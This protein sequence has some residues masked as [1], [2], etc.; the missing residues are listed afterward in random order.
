[1][2]LS[3]DKSYILSETKIKNVFHEIDD[4]NPELV[5]IDSIQ[6][7]QTQ[8]I[9]SS[10]GSVSQIKECTSELIGLQKKPMFLFF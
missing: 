1:M 5:I 6:T 2:N 9:D 4:L 10:P 8:Y 7:L 3:N